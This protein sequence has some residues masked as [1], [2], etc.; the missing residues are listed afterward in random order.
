MYTHLKISY[1][2]NEFKKNGQWLTE[3]GVSF[4]SFC[5]QRSSICQ[6]LGYDKL[7]KNCSDS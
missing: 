7:V 3:V 1:Y 6:G 5:G 4:R 2:N